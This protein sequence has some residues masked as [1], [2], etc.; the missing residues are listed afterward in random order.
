M[1]EPNLPNLIAGMSGFVSLV[2]WLV[3]MGVLLF[4]SAFFSSSEAALFYLRRAQRRRLASGGVGQRRAAAL[5]AEPERLLSAVLFCNLTVNVAYFAIASIVGIQLE[6]QGYGAAAGLFSLGSL[7]TLIVFSEMLPKSLA[8]LQPAKVAA[9]AAIPLSTAVRLLDPIM[10]VLQTVNLLSRRLLWPTFAAE[11]YLRV[12]DLE[13][14]VRLSTHD[15]ALLEQEQQVL[16]VIVALSQLRADELMRPRPQVLTFTPPVMLD[17]LQG[18]MPAS[19]YL[20]ITEVES[21]EIAGAV[22]LRNLSS[23]PTKNLEHHAQPVVYV[24]WCTTAA[25]ALE[26]MQ[27]QARDVAA[28]VN[29]HGETIGVLTIDDILDTIFSPVASRTERLLHR[30]PIWR[31]DAETWVV[32]GMTSLRRLIRHFNISRPASKSLTVSGVI[33]ETLERLAEPGDECRWGPFHFKVLE[34][35]PHGPRMVQLRFEPNEEEPS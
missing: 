15:A 14:A 33:Q 9:L 19:G 22:A 11:P 18:R 23:L 25:R 16:E 27:R 7:M 29:E 12:G 24:P 10:P 1:I 32:T 4:A 31:V 20:L 21:E 28:V 8:V 35:G 17:D 26:E 30:R 6:Q 34:T 3:A 5:L 2:P 13:R